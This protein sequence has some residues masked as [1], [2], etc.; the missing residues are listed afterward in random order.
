MADIALSVSRLEGVGDSCGSP[1]TTG[2]LCWG[3]WTLLGLLWKGVEGKVAATT[4]AGRIVGCA[5]RHLL[6]Q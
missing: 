4:A 2:R 1:P 3:G 5:D 6:R